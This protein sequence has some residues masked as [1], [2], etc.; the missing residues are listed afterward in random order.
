[1]AAGSRGLP[2]LSQ[3]RTGHHVGLN[4]DGNLRSHRPL[5]TPADAGAGRKEIALSRRGDHAI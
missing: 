3:P 1:M 2:D 5:R 4:S